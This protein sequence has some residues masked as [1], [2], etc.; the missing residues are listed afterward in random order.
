MTPI[1]D[2]ESR[3]VTKQATDLVFAG[4]KVRLA[5]QIDYPQAAPPTGGYPLLFILHHTGGHTRE[6]Y[7]D[8]AEVGLGAGYAVFRWDKRGTG[9]SG[10]GG[11]GSTTQDAVNAY[12]IALEQPFINHAY[13][14]ILAPGSGTMLLGN[15]YGLFARIQNPHGVLLTGNMLDEQAILAIDTRLKII[16][17]GDDWRPVETFGQA[18][19]DAHNQTYRHGAGFFVAPYADRYLMDTRQTPPVFHQ[20]ARLVIHDW[21]ESLCPASTST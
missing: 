10:G 12:E 1:R 13:T 9:R 6:A 3:Q 8:F 16:M 18:A 7:Q 20:E 17:G 21:L 2:K 14:V 19:C 5:G 15:S 4:D 11:R